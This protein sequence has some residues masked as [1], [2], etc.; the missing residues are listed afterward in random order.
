V[1]ELDFE[2]NRLIVGFAD[3]FEISAIVR[4]PAPPLTA[5][6]T[7]LLVLSGDQMVI[8]FREVRTDR[9]FTRRLPKLAR[10]DL[11][12]QEVAAFLGVPSVEYVILMYNGRAL[13][14]SILLNRL[15][16][17]GELSVLISREPQAVLLL[18]A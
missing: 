1:S 10:V 12:N 13:A 2:S 5:S 18:S 6:F 3:R 17:A 16:L 8:R 15:R 7:R 11:A 9:A 4:D 14:G